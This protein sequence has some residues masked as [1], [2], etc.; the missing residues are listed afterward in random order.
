[1]SD[2]ERLIAAHTDIGRLTA[3]CHMFLV[4]INS[5]ELV[6]DDQAKRITELEGAIRKYELSCSYTN[7]ELLF[8]ALAKG[9][10][11]SES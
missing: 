9:E 1:M 11:D 6:I 4:N 10:N 7:R 2:L 8:E 5:L 3:E